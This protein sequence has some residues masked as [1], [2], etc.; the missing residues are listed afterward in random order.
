MTTPSALGQSGSADVLMDRNVLTPLWVVF[1]LAMGPAVALGLSRF[2]YALLLPAMRTDLGWSFAD[3]GAMNT[4]NAVGYLAGAWVAAPM[5]KKLGDKVVFA[6]GLLFTALAVFATGLTANFTMLLILRLIAGLSGAVAFVAGAALTSA[7]AAGGPK[8]RAPTWLGIY[9]SGA[10]IGVIASALGVLPLLDLTG[11]RGGWF[12]LGGLSLLATALGC[13][14]LRRSP[15][16]DHSPFGSARGGGWSPWFMARQLIAYGLYGA[17]YIAYATFIVAFLR[18][19]QGFSNEN[20]AVFWSIVGFASVA[21]A[22]LWGPILARLSGGRGTAVTI[23]VVAVG[24]AVPLFW[25][26]IFGAYLSA[27]L[28]GGSFLSVV[29]SVTAFARKAARPHAWTAAIAALTIVFGLGQ[30]IGPVL[31]GALSDGENGVRT[32]LWLSVGILIIA[33]MIAVFQPE[34]SAQQ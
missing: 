13:L 14:V 11:W 15:A 1:G 2:A 17:G 29:A 25:S 22:F 6:I 23:A 7:G 27:V 3:A 32:G 20:V 8:S 31:S 10:G 5:G 26:G 4:A 18:D 24:A 12:M 19:E 33:S 30:C 21:A 34:P 9:F 28:F 16:P